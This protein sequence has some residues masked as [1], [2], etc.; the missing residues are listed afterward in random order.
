[1][2]ILF[3]I[4]LC[5]ISW[6]SY[7]F[8]IFLVHIF[9]IFVNWI[10]TK[11]PFFGKILISSFYEI[12]LFLPFLIS[13]YFLGKSRQYTLD[14]VLFYASVSTLISLWHINFHH[15]VSLQEYLIFY[16]MPALGALLPAIYKKI[17]PILI[18]N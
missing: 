10:Y 13:S 7:I 2:K 15:S 9:S 18:I 5:L 4:F 8:H 16:S 3:T 14:R 17:K 11:T 1:M 12:A 6:I